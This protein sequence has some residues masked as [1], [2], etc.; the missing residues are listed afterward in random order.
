[1]EA[2]DSLQKPEVR[3]SF[4]QGYST[5]SWEAKGTQLYYLGNHLTWKVQSEP[6]ILT[7]TGIEKRPP[8]QASHKMARSPQRLRIWKPGEALYT[9]S[10]HGGAFKLW[11]LKNVLVAPY[12]TRYRWLW[13]VS[14]TQVSTEASFKLNGPQQMAVSLRTPQIWKRG[15]ESF[16][17]WA[18][19]CFR[20][21]KRQ[22]STSFVWD[23]GPLI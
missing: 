1:M 20:T 13:S 11:K 21:P 23:C 10:Q 18:P 3:S 5:G 2:L 22:T 17:N 4:P 8:F 9:T 6:E 12:V 7:P 19:V 16:E 14:Y 15:R